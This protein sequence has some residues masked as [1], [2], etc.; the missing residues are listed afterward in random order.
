MPFSKVAR[1]H[2]HA[3]NV[4][5]ASHIRLG[6]EPVALCVPGL[7]PSE[8][9]QVN[10]IREGDVVRAIEIVCTCGKRIVLNCVY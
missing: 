9:P 7:Q 10:L 5:P 4:I 1:P 2:L 8:Q 3:N 6:A